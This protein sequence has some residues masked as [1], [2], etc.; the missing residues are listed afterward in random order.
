VAY[1]GTV[2][3]RGASTGG[4]AIDHVTS[5]SSSMNIWLDENRNAVGAV[6]GLCVG[7]ALAFVV[8]AR[9]RPADG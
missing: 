7:A 2:E 5:W 9:R 3:I 1:Y 4:S 6:L 8:L